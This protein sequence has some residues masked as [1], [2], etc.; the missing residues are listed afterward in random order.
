MPI[1]GH[2][3]EEEEPQ[4]HRANIFDVTHSRPSMP[5]DLR[6]DR[7]LPRPAP[8]QCSPVGRRW[9]DIADSMASTSC[10]GSNGFFS[11]VTAGDCSRIAL[12][13]A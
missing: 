9:A 5:C 7:P 6:V 4:S 12:K 13:F 1:R 10:C 8:G 11:T 3:G 2:S